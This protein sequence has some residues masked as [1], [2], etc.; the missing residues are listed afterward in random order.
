MFLFRGNSYI[1]DR[2]EK[3]QKLR[4]TK[5]EKHQQLNPSVE[6]GRNKEEF[7]LPTVSQS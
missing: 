7:L 4:K 6:A 1:R 3:K 2:R 5:G